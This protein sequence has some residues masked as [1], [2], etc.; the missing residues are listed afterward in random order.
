MGESWPCSLLFP[1]LCLLVADSSGCW[2]HGDERA[3]GEGRAARSHPTR[4]REVLGLLLPS[5]VVWSCS[6]WPY[7]SS[8]A[9]TTS[10]SFG[11]RSNACS[12]RPAQGLD[13]WGRMQRWAWEQS[14]AL[15]SG[16]DIS[17]GY[18][19]SLCDLPSPGM[20]L[21][22]PLSSLQLYVPMPCL[23]N[24]QPKRASVRHKIMRTSC[25]GLTLPG[26]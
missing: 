22:L 20:C 24:T 9:L 7:P 3:W 17:G 23:I 8:P 13:A 12:Q 16:L 11:R 10:P 5:A 1:H 4:Q 19:P 25:P 15:V 2:G 6:C 26:R 14:L 18:Q 21:R